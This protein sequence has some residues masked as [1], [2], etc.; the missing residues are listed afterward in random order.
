MRERENFF[1]TFNDCTKTNDL[2]MGVKFFEWALQ[3]IRE[4]TCVRSTS[5]CM[6]GS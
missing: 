3:D 2:E 6:S 1:E 4:G 5:E